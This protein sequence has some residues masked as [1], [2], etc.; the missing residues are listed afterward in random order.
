[1]IEDMNITIQIWTLVGVVIFVIMN[2]R[3]IANMKNK[4]DI[5]MT[6]IRDKVKHLERN[7]ARIWDTLQSHDKRLDKWDISLAEI[8][9]KLVGIETLLIEIKKDIK[10]GK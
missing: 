8:K 9:T 2:T 10:H 4:V 6:R 1:M 3:K 7:K 5:Q